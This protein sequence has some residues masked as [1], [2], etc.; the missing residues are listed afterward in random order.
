[1]TKTNEVTI[2]IVTYHPDERFSHNLAALGKYTA[3]A[4]ICDNSEHGTL[5]EFGASLFEVVQTGTNHGLGYYYNYCFDIADAKGSEFILFLDQDSLVSEQDIDLLLRDARSINTKDPSF[6]AIG[7][8]IHNLNSDSSITY[9]DRGG[10]YPRKIGGG[11]NEEIVP[12]AYVISSGM[13][14]TTESMKNIGKFR[15]DFFI[16][17]IDIEWCLRASTLG[18][19][20]YLSRNVVVQH[21]L[22]EHAS[23]KG[24]AISI[25][26]PLR[27]R[28]RVR[29]GIYMM[30]YCSIPLAWRAKLLVGTIKMV[31]VNSRV[32]RHITLPS[33]GIFKA[34]LGGIVGR[35]GKMQ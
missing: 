16:D 27:M 6:C 29:N 19:N 20:I 22:G 10:V 18:Y 14:V 24:T 7:P 5:Q 31:W 33:G 21:S 13:L 9:F 28:Y 8:T 3:N 1:M 2:C 23:Y 26:G 32:N 25:H 17:L 12:V 30:L 35:L 34:A 11:L 4:V 15:S